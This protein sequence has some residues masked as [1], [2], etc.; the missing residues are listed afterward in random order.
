[1][2]KPLF[3]LMILALLVAGC[4]LTMDSNMEVV[5]KETVRLAPGGRITM[6]HR[7]T[8]SYYGDNLGE[9]LNPTDLVLDSS[10]RLC[11][12]DSGNR[13]VQIFD[14]D[15]G[16]YRAYDYDFGGG[17]R[18]YSFQDISVNQQGHIFLAD[19]G[20]GTVIKFTDVSTAFVVSESTTPL[21]SAGSLIRDDATIT[22]SADVPGHPLSLVASWVGE[23]WVSSDEELFQF[24]SRGGLGE[25]LYPT[26]E[27]FE[28][29]NDIIDL[30]IDYDRSFWALTET[31][32]VYH[33][34][35][36]ARIQGSFDT[37]LKSPA[38]LAA[39]GGV[40]AV[41]DNLDNIVQLYREDGRL[42]DELELTADDGTVLLQPAG[43]A[44]SFEDRLLYLANTGSH[45]IEIF[46][47][48]VWEPA[49]ATVDEPVEVVEEPLPETVI[50]TVMDDGPKEEPPA[51]EE[52]VEV[53]PVSEEASETAEE[54]LPENENED[55]TP[56]D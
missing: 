23:L 5:T 9:L 13:R 26:G 3:L 53:E 55:D 31:G 49:E 12:L 28:H 8:L 24:D 48:S 29:I 51:T 44:L 42:L 41:V 15:G 4:Q 16:L 45:T 43:V 54:P 33:I 7:D 21:S 56:E 38:A 40:I 27:G 32:M 1:M 50:D 47:L 22:G 46:D 30:E 39:D 20:A 17:E 14:Q 10:G 18:A 37:K 52:E 25:V 34:D 2:K 6:Y 35:Y 11:V 36:R 19:A